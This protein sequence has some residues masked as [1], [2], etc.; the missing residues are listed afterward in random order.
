M[1]IHELIVI[2]W[3]YV[4]DYTRKCRRQDTDYGLRFDRRKG[5]A[6]GDGCQQ[7]CRQ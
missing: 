5:C 1:I 7:Q 3:G 2:A 4:A 6:T